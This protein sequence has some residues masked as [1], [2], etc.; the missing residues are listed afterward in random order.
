VIGA[1]PEIAV[2]LQSVSHTD[3]HGANPKQWNYRRL[4]FFENRLVG[5]VLIGDMHA[6]VDLVNVIRS[7]K[8]VWDERASL[9]TL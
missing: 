4:F 1:T 3:F 9:L 7:K 6:K 5:A 8:Q 2:E